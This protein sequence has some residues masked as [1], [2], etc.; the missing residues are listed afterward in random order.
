MKTMPQ[1]IEL[2]TPVALIVDL[3]EHSLTR[4]QIG[5]VVE[6]LEHNGET[7]FLVDH[8]RSPGL[9]ALRVLCGEIEP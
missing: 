7:A 5:T 3:P 2:L 9:C 1:P 6:H 8:P 4:G